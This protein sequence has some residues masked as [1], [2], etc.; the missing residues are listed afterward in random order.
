MTH[1][2][3]DAPLMISS[4]SG[5]DIL[6]SQIQELE[7]NHDFWQGAAVWLALAIFIAPAA[8]FI[9]AG[10]IPGFWLIAAIAPGLEVAALIMA[11]RRARQLSAAQS[12]LNREK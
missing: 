7:R 2:S 3:S 12:A 6:S 9:L 5:I 11:K 8:V 4:E 1:Q 10:L